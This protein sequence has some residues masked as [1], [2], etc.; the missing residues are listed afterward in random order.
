MIKNTSPDK[1]WRPESLKKQLQ[2]FE[3]FSTDL[4]IVGQDLLRAFYGCF[5]GSFV[6]QVISKGFTSKFLYENNPNRNSYKSSHKLALILFLSLRKNQKPES[7]F[8]QVVW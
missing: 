2:Q 3:N 8:Q 4:A 1:S 5:I 7:G 6:I